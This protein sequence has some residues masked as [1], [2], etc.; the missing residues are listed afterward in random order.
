[1]SGSLELLPD[2]LLAVTMTTVDGGNTWLVNSCNAASTTAE[3]AE[4]TAKEPF[5]AEKPLW[6]RGRN[7]VRCC[8]TRDCLHPLS[9]RT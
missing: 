2:S 8:G 9:N 3:G 5:L 6:E 1:M 7:G 4:K